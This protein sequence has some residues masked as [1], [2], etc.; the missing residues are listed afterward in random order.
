MDAHRTAAKPSGAT[1][2]DPRQ[3][4]RVHL[5]VPVK[6]F[7]DIKSTESYSCC[8]YELSMTGARVAAA[9]GIREPGQIIYV[10]R[11]NRRA[12][13]Q[14]VWVGKPDTSQ[15]GQMGVI[16][17]EPANVIWENEIKTRI[18]RG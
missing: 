7:P 2:V 13:Y 16:S 11:Q 9:P 12:R 4:N 1:A 8:T 3:E 5:A 15:A 18:L 14:V 17:L 6:V 10:Q